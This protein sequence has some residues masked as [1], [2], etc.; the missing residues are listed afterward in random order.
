M[1]ET[2]T[3]IAVFNP[4]GTKKIKRGLVVPDDFELPPGYVRHHQVLDD[5]RELPAVLMF[6]PDSPPVDENG[7]PIPVPED[8][9][10]TPENAPPGLP[11]EYLK[12]PED[13]GPEGGE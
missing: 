12:L 1:A 8:R 3:G 6:N 5:G 7:N 10:V 2:P 9:L 11:L 4:P 13:V